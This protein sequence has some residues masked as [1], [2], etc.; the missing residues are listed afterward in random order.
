M[1]SSDAPI[2]L[3]R[4]A[5]VLADTVREGGAIAARM[6]REGAE[7]WTKSDNSPV[8]E[9]DL[10]VDRF[11][12]AHLPPLVEGSG[13]LSEETADTP[14][15][16][17]RRR[18]WVVDPIDG[19]RAFIEGRPEW[20]VSV[21]LVEDG[22]PIAG[23]VFDAC[24]DVTFEA[25]R[26]LGATRNGEPLVTPDPPQLGGARVGGPKSL[27]GPLEPYGVSRGPWLYALANRLV[28]VASGG[29]D[30]AIARPNAH[31][32]DIAAAHLI[33]EEAGALL[34]NFDGA[35]PGYNRPTT[36]HGGLVAAPPARHRALLAALDAERETLAALE[37]YR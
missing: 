2:D 7:R 1:P 26:G 23:V 6:F 14:E 5:G 22:A 11:L 24:N 17:T 8:T 3:E 9:A 29:L 19:T 15:R 20:V 32:W 16:L 33:L 35:I 27:L 10:A 34:T 12:A 13:W 18:V 30:A 28:K 4:L 21:A 36:R 37:P 25:F 31:D